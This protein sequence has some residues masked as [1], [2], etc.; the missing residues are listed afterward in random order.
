ML[1]VFI[2]LILFEL[3]LF[4]LSKNKFISLILLGFVFFTLAES[5][6]LGDLKLEKENYVYDTYTNQIE[7]IDYSYDFIPYQNLSILADGFLWLGFIIII[8]AFI[9][10]LY[11]LFLGNH[12]I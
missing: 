3:Y 6:Y 1:D 12:F 10:E 2:L 7:E 9:D 5:I 8:I 4:H 11:Y